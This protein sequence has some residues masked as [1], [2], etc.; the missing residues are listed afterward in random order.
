MA[1]LTAKLK[2]TKIKVELEGVTS[3]GQPV[4]ARG[5][6]V[7]ER[8]PLSILP[9]HIDVTAGWGR[10]APRFGCPTS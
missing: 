10:F 9:P 6:L 2:I 1:D 5:D 7:E 3:D 8:N 4:K